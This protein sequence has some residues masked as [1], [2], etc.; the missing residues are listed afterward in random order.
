MRIVASSGVQ[1]AKF[2]ELPGG[3]FEL[4]LHYG[5]TVD[6]ILAAASDLA[7]KPPLATFIAL[8]ADPDFPR[9]FQGVGE[10]L[11]ISPA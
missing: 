1:N 10:T 11:I 6:D 9:N 7:N 2:S 3:D 4:L 5:H 8:W